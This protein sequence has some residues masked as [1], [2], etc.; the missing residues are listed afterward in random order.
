M[1]RDI[2]RNIPDGP[3]LHAEFHEELALA[4]RMLDQQKHDKNKLYSIHA[5]EVDFIAKGKVHK[6]YDF[7]L[8][9]SVATTSRD[10]FVIGMQALPGN[11]FEGNALTGALA[12]IGRVTGILLERCYVDNGHRGHGGG[13]IV[14]VYLRAAARGDTDHQEGTAAT[15]CSGAGVGH[16]KEDGKLDRNWLKGSIGD[17]TNALLR[18]V[19]Q[20]LRLIFRKLREMLSFFALFSFSI[21]FPTA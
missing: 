2:L 13:I 16:M 12:Q 4:E 17:N 3:D 18:G 10:N 6:K 19:G 14:G 5:P 8:K 15:E 21:N 11:P 20:K 9:V 1:Y 7:G